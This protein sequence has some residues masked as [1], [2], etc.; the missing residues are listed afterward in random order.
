VRVSLRALMAGARAGAVMAQPCS[1]WTGPEPRLSA[2]GTAEGSVGAACARQSGAVRA[3]L[4]SAETGARAEAR[5]SARAAVRRMQGFPQL[6]PPKK[7]PRGGARGF[8]VRRRRGAKTRESASG[9]WAFRALDDPTMPSATAAHSSRGNREKNKAG[10]EPTPT[11]ACIEIVCVLLL[12]QFYAYGVKRYEFQWRINVIEAVESE[13]M[14]AGRAALDRA[15][16]GAL[17]PRP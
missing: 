9:A 10:Y 12:G 6:V 15:G 8:E 3:K 11:P 7:K 13:V 1:A 14:P 17:K 2:L 16:L 5:S 4:G